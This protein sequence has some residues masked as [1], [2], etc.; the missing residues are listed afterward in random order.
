MTFLRTGAMLGALAVSGLAHAQADAGAAFFAGLGAL[1]GSYFEGASVYPR[2]PGDPF[3]GK[4]LVAHVASC[5]ANEIRIPFTVGED[6]SRT[7]IIRKTPAGLELKHD[8]RH[9]D[10]TPDAQ[11]MYGG[12][13]GGQGTA[14]AQSFHADAYTA[15]L[16]PAAATNVWTISLAADGRAMAY[17][18]ERG[19]KPRFRAEL[20]LRASPPPPSAP[21][22]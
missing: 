21:R 9:E 19:G 18:L 8:H 10:G 11:T 6:K 16:I 20:A 7:W 17:N 14:L 1:C 15:A 22:R 3:A 5:T 13:A 12:L 4:K 2:D